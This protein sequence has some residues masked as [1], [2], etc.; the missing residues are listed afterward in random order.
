MVGIAI[1]VLALV[2]AALTIWLIDRAN[3]R[4]AIVV[5]T[6]VVLILI[7]EY[8]LASSGTLRDWTRRPPPFAMAVAVPIVLA[9]VLALSSVGRRVATT[10]SFASIIAIQAFRFPL[11][12]AMHHAATIGLMPPQ[13]SYGGRNFDIVTGVL[14]IPVAWISAR[15]ARARP[16]VFWWNLL[17]TALLI[18]IV[19]IAVAS[20]PIFAA[21][22]PEHLNTWVA[23]PPYVWLPAILVPTAV[24][25][26]TLV[27][28]KLL[29]PTS[30]Q[31]R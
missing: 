16:I 26:H 29:I 24:L 27:W 22:G 6:A 13:M 23:D 14:A 9:L 15:S 30:R 7:G 2:V 11:E 18:N 5:A 19:A 8:A 10:A 21:F 25:G 4:A 20:T 17:G 1:S 12:L 31:I 28:R 3:R